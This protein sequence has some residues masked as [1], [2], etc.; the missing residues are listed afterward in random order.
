YE[1]SDRGTSWLGPLVYGLAVQ[2]T[3]SYRVAMLSLIVF[4]VMGLALLARVSL[5]RGV[6]DVHGDE[7]ASVEMS[8]VGGGA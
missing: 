1:L 4:F 5:P 8:L 7:I 2:F 6:R 3:G